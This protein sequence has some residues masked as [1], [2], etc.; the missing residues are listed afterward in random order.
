MAEK[1]GRFIVFCDRLLLVA[2][3]KFSDKLNR[4]NC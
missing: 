1:N 3:N 2:N 4:P